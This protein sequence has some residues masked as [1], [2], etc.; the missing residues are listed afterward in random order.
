MVFKRGVGRDFA[1][2]PGGCFEMSRHSACH[3]WS[4]VLLAS[5]EGRQGQMPVLQ[6]TGWPSMTKN[7]LFRCQHHCCWDACRMQGFLTWWYM[8]TTWRLLK[9][10]FWTPHPQ[11][12]ILQYVWSGTQK[13]VF[14]TSSP[15]MLTLLVWGPHF[16]SQ[17]STVY[18]FYTVLPQF[19]Q[20][21]FK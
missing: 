9:T 19:Y 12:L 1:P 3:N 15:V 7:Y 16:E 6:C 10:S 20:E 5:S 4:E 17:C 11:F 2:A 13:S 21:V 8:S 14:L 18:F